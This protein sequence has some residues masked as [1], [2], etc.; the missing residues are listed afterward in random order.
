[1]KPKKLTVVTGHYGSGKTNFT[2]NLALFYAKMG[3]KCAVIDLDIVNPYFRTADFAE[4]FRANKITLHAPAY[5]NSN[6]DLPTLSLD[7]SA[8]LAGEEL[9]LVD[10]G[11]DDE[12]AKAL[13]QYAPIIKRC[14]D[15]EL[16]YVVNKYRYLTK[17]PDEA[18]YLLKEIEA[19]GRLSC[20]GIVNNSNLG[21]ET[22]KEH[23]RAS[24][25]YAREIARTAK[26]PIAATCARA[27]LIPEE[28][29]EPFPIEIYVKNPW[30]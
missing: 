27:E 13:G 15:R 28:A 7:F 20:G 29:D 16:L 22:T 4:L 24:L 26:L 2:V 23:I 11:G 1:M 18:L 14:P 12:G 10:V 9:I 19:A 3:K 21:A 6:L 17:E 5:A 25:P 30:V 8:L